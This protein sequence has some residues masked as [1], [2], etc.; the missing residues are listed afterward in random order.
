[1]EILSGKL[2]Y[3]CIAILTAKPVNLLKF[4]IVAIGS[5]AP[6]YSIHTS[7][8]ESLRLIAEQE[9]FMHTE[10]N[11]DGYSIVAVHYKTPECHYEQA[12]RHKAVN[13]LS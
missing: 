1:M 9:S 4:M 10:K 5:S 6:T 8:D 12:D 13:N 3:V 7:D 2:F 11:E